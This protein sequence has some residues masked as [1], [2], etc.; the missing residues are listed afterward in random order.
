MFPD[1]CS[2][3]RIPDP[4]GIPSHIIARKGSFTFN[5]NTYSQLYF[6]PLNTYGPFGIA[7]FGATPVPG[8]YDLKG[9]TATG[10]YLDPYSEF[11][12]D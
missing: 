8:E 4:Y 12:E 6:T 10:V 11:V 7:L 1:V 9:S 3:V 2:P 5:S